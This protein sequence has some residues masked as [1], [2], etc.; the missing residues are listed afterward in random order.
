MDWSVALQFVLNFVII[1]VVVGFV[2]V[3]LFG[4]TDKLSTLKDDFIRWR[5]RYSKW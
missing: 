2:V 4:F 5:H 3:K 1:A